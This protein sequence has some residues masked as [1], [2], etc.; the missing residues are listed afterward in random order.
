MHVFRGQVDAC[1]HCAV[2]SL[3]ATRAHM[4]ARCIALD[5][6]GAATCRLPAGFMARRSE[7][8]TQV[9]KVWA[10]IYKACGE[11]CVKH[12]IEHCQASARACRGCAQELEKMTN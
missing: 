9:C 6:D 7:F 11:E 4:M 12:S 5:I 10:E 2:S 8:M 1:D 3:Q